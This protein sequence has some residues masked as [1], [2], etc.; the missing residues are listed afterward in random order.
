MKHPLCG[1]GSTVFLKYTFTFS[2]YL[3]F[4]FYPRIGI[5]DGTELLSPEQ[6]TMHMPFEG[7]VRWNTFATTTLKLS[8]LPRNTKLCFTLYALKSKKKVDKAE[9]IGWVNCLVRYG[10]AMRAKHS[11]QFRLQIFN[12]KH[13]LRTG[14]V[15]LKMWPNGE[16]K[17]EYT[18]TS[19]R[20]DIIHALLLHG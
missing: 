12:Y 1:K 10:L 2:L 5:Y 3:I 9:P 17:P 11:F 19:V 6:V 13:E 7:N 18:C 14:K 16:A 4:I 15:L 20:H 8:D